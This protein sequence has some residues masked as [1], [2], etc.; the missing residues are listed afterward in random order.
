M[1]ERGAH[2]FNLVARRPKARSHV[3][4][5][6]SRAP[7]FLNDLA[8]SLRTQPEVS[9]RSEREFQIANALL[10]VDGR[11]QNPRPDIG[12]RGVQVVGRRERPSSPGPTHQGGRRVL[13]GRGRD[14]SRVSR[15]CARLAAA[16]C[17]P[18]YLA[19]NRR[20]PLTPPVPGLARTGAGSSRSV[21]R[22]ENAFGF[23]SQDDAYL[24]PLASNPLCGRRYSEPTR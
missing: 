9:S 17:A 5:S 16:G 11:R 6:P 12:W 14:G 7:D 8:R 15:F 4:P 19:L 22:G 3:A 10:T 23:A 2:A 13:A 1:L 21:G 18:R 20:T 24:K